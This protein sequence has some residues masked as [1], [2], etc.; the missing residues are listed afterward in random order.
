MIH[1]PVPRTTDLS[2]LTR[3]DWGHYKSAHKKIDQATSL[4]LTEVSAYG[5]IINL[6]INGELQ[7]LTKKKVRWSTM[8]YF[9]NL[10]R[11][12]MLKHGLILIKGE[13]E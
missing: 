8:E 5:A 6:R 1:T 2:R 12:E 10:P 3:C 11:K 4:R 7:Q 13:T 9:F